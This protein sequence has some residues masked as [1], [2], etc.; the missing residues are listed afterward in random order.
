MLQVYIM[1]ISQ[2]DNFVNDNE[3]RIKGSC[4]F[5]R[6]E[7]ERNGRNLSQTVCNIKNYLYASVYHVVN[8]D[9]F[10]GIIRK[11]FSPLEDFMKRIKKIKFCD[12]LLVNVKQIAEIYIDNFKDGFHSHNCRSVIAL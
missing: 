9:C 12:W 11:Y 6:S 1:N 8:E 10:P 4:T 5:F 2:K 7:L 3:T